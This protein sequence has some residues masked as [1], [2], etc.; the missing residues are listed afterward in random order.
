MLCLLCGEKIKVGKY[1][2][3]ISLI[4]EMEHD[5]KQGVLSTSWRSIIREI[6][7]NHLNGNNEELE[8]WILLA[9]RKAQE[10]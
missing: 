10:Q 1:H 5:N 8:D 9:E 2:Y 7:R 6:K 4:D 3:C